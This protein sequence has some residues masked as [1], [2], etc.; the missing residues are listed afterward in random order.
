MHEEELRSLLL[1]Y[2]QFEELNNLVESLFAAFRPLVATATR[3]SG[4]CFA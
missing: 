1:V 4:R 3:R 2:N